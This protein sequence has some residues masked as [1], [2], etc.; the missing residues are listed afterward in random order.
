MPDAWEYLLVNMIAWLAVMSN[1]GARGEA[2]CY[3][4]ALQ[5]PK[6]HS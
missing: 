5:V 4:T 1:A 6:Y 3:F 2:E